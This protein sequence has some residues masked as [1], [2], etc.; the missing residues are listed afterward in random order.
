MNFPRGLYSLLKSNMYIILTYCINSGPYSGGK[1][2][3]RGRR[4]LT[5]TQEL[6]IGL[7]FYASGSFQSIAGLL[8]GNLI[9]VLYLGQ[10]HI[11]MK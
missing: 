5:P 7:A 4:P 8:I 1:G 6:C 2:G 10:K 3:G 9:T 11:G